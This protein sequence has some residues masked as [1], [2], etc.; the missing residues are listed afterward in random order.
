M[1]I[2]GLVVGPVGAN[3]YV[4]GDGQSKEGAIIDPGDEPERILQVV[5]ETSLQIRFIIATHGHFD[6]SAATKRLKEELETD[7]LLHRDDLPYVRRS[8]Q[9]AQEWGIFIEQ[10]PDPDRY[11]K[12]GEVL[13]LGALELKIIHTPGHSPGG[14]SIY[15]PAE[16][17]LFS[18]DTL[19]QGSV[20]RTDFDGGSMEVL[21][22]SIKKSLYTLPDSTIVYTGHGE[23]TTIG[24]EKIHNYFV[25]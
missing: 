1:I 9:K 14:I 6:H 23:P 10:V 25:R 7:F 3:C 11:I 15:I 2:K 20:G 22:S 4:I 18:G 24:D 19:F 13:K 8:K 5:R 12:D 21:T 17:V 16:N